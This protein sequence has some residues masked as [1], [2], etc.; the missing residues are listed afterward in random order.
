MARRASRLFLERLVASP[1]FDNN[2]H[3]VLPYILGTLRYEDGKARTAT[4]VDAGNSYESRRVPKNKKLKMCIFVLDGDG[5]KLS[6]IKA[7]NN[8]NQ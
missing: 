3:P 1:A 5:N 4:A 8:Q 2:P 7:L 6:F